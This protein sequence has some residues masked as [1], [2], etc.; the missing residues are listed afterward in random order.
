M[1]DFKSVSVSRSDEIRFRM[2]LSNRLDPASDEGGSGAV[3][4]A[5]GWS[6][7]GWSAFD[8]SVSVGRVICAEAPIG[9]DA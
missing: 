6:A 3:A 1:Y 5:F 7:F 4:V 2:F 8:R 9:L